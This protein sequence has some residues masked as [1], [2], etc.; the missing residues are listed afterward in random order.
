MEPSTTGA[1][2]LLII[3][4]SMGSG[5]STI[6]G[7]ASDLLTLQGIPHA[8]IDL[9]TLG[10]YH[11]PVE[12]DGSSV[13]LRN[14]QCVWGN[15]SALGLKRLLL[16]RAIETRMALDACRQAVAAKRTVMCRLRVNVAT[17]QRRVRLREPGP[18]QQ[19]FVARVAVLEDLIDRAQLEDFSITNEDGSV[20]EVAREMLLR[21]GWL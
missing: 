1:E 9:D 11:L 10:I 12:V 21:A 5:K 16:A 15:Y 17:M 8:A 2:E 18:F 20:T 19:N 3:T 6:L 4:G 13:G 14:L 7:A